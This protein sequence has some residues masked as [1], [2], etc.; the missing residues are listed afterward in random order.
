MK[1]F[2]I[3]F[4]YAIFYVWKHVEAENVL[5]DI[6]TDCKV[7]TQFDEII[8]WCEWKAKAALWENLLFS[9]S[10]EDWN[11]FFPTPQMFL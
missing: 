1:L 2:A 3:R 6:A 5:G 7:K 4:F 8:F 10:E 9:L 11:Q